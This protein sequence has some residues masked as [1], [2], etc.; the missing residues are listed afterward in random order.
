[1]GSHCVRWLGL[2]LLLLVF[3]GS[4]AAHSAESRLVAIG[5]IHGAAEQFRALLQEAGLLDD[6]QRWSGGSDTF[7]QT[8]DLLDRGNGVRVMLDGR[9]SLKHIGDVEVVGM[10]LT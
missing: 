6:E 7:V 10:G 8:G 2:I 3:L 5:D 9:I 4:P 1:M